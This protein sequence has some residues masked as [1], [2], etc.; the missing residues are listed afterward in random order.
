MYRIELVTSKGKVFLGPFVYTAEKVKERLK[1]LA[2]LANDKRATIRAVNVETYP[3]IAFYTSKD[4]K[5]YGEIFQKRI[6]LIRFEWDKKEAREG[7]I[8]DG[9]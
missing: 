7:R 2:W 5:R 9:N 3:L 6:R 4:T 1:K 8:N